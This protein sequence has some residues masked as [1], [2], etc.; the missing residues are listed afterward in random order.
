ME[1][2]LDEQ[3][4]N[5]GYNDKSSSFFLRV[6][7]RVVG[8]AA[9]LFPLLTITILIHVV[10]RYLCGINFVWLEE[11][12]WQLYAYLASF[13][14]VFSF[15]TNDHV[16]LDLFRH[17]FSRKSQSVIE[18]AGLV[19]FVF[20]FSILLAWHGFLAV[21]QSFSIGEHSVNEQGLPFTFIVKLALPL[22]FSII[23]IVAMVRLM[24]LAVANRQALDSST[25]TNTLNQLWNCLLY[26]SPSPRD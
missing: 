13:G 18:M 14:V 8:L 17:R 15:L 7:H 10:L 16:R 9:L 11:L 19:F 4:L 26:T 6:L 2:T 25:P 12:H 5:D 20:P 23:L 22:S 24:E 3:I 21:G 1:E